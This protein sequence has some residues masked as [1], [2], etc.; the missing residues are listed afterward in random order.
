MV[1]VNRANF[2][3]RLSLYCANLVSV[4]QIS[5]LH[6]TAAGIAERDIHPGDVAPTGLAIG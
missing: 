5:L 1:V 3:G 2:H 6:H 4:A